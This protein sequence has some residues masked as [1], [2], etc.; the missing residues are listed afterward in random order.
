MKI[1]DIELFLIFG[2]WYN[3]IGLVEVGICSIC[4]N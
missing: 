4:T 1:K 2:I 3:Y